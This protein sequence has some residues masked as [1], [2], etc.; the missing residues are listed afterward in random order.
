MEG[1]RLKLR[2]AEARIP[3]ACGKLQSVSL[4]HQLKEGKLGRRGIL[5]P[6]IFF[7]ISSIVNRRSQGVSQRK[8]INS[9]Q[10][11]T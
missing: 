2:L 3:W 10:F 1:G 9:S 5:F 6:Y 11:F 8:S 4:S 7:H